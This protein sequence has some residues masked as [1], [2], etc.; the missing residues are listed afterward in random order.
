MSS[1]M[2]EVRVTDPSSLL[3]HIID[4]INSHSR[5]KM[6]WWFHVEYFPDLNACLQI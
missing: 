2:I 4:H 6:E 1:K 5:F 3:N